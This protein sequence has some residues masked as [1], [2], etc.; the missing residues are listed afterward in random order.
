VS[1]VYLLWERFFIGQVAF[2]CQAGDDHPDEDDDIE[3]VEP[4]NVE[5]GADE[6]STV[7]F[8]E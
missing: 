1:S 6:T 8:Q 5:V 4:V 7:N 3:F 2:T